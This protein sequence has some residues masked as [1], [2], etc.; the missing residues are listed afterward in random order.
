MAALRPPTTHAIPCMCGGMPHDPPPLLPRHLTGQRTR[1]T[2]ASKQTLFSLVYLSQPK[3][4]KASSLHDA[5]KCLHDTEIFELFGFDCCV[6]PSARSSVSQSLVVLRLLPRL[7]LL[8]ATEVSHPRYFLVHVFRLCL[9]S[10]PLSRP[11]L[12][13]LISSNPLRFEASWPSTCRWMARTSTLR[14]RRHGCHSWDPTRATR[15]RSAAQKSRSSCSVGVRR[16]ILR[17]GLDGVGERA[18]GAGL[19]TACIL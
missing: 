9:F 17:R 18:D 14:A 12:L 5:P 8:H 11:S 10:N 15:T 19:G 13:V 2:D 7:L 1:P 6:R 3:I 16:C 4:C